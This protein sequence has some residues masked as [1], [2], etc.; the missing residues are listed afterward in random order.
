MTDSRTPADRL[1][2]AHSS[3]ARTTRIPGHTFAG[4]PPGNL[5]GACHPSAA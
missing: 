1:M 4:S 3:A 2:T 5:L